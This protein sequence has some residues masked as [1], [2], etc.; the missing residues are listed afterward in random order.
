MAEI[1]ISVKNNTPNI[2]VS[3]G[4]KKIT[5]DSEL[6]ATS[7]NPVQN[8]AVT[9]ALADKV[10]KVEGKGLSSNDYTIEDKQK[11][12]GLPTSQELTSVFEQ[13]INK[14]T[15]VDENSTDTQYPSALAVYYSSLGVEARINAKL[16]EYVHKGTD[17]TN[18]ISTAEPAAAYYPTAKAVKDYAEPKTTVVDIPDQPPTIDLTLGQNNTDTRNVICN[19]TRLNLT[20][21]NG[22]YDNDY[23][24]GLSFKTYETP[25]HI[26]YAA[27]GIIQWIGTDCFIS[28]DNK[29]IFKPS[30]NT[31][32][33]IVFYYNGGNYIVGLVNGYKV[34]TGNQEANA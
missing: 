34:A 13:K 8:K 6:S 12:A 23:I 24:Q 17:S 5:V 21:P 1:K 3:S 31:H 15:A 2:N 32:Y 22:E 7:E 11:L 25:T 18:D 4:G 26:S 27:T 20:F 29:S 14:V 30:A 16:C 28:D 33:D 10:D 19:T 9:A